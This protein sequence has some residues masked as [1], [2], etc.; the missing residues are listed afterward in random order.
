MERTGE[1]EIFSHIVNFENLIYY[2]KGPGKDIDFNDFNDAVTLFD[3]I[4]SKKKKKKIK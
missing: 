3:D 2:F 1:N 4:K